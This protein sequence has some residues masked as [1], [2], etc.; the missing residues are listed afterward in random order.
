M[1]QS[2]LG[3]SLACGLLVSSFSGVAFAGQQTVRTGPRGNSQSTTRAV[4]GN[5]QQTVRTG[6]GGNSQT[7]TRTWGNNQQQTVR[8]GPGGNSQT[9]TRTRTP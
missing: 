7:T 6:P 8:T 4:T 3:I 5:Q 1:R 2:I 9:T